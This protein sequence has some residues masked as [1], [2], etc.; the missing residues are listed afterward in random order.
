LIWSGGCSFSMFYSR[1][2]FADLIFSDS[3]V[4]LRPMAHAQRSADLVAGRALLRAARLVSCDA[5]DSAHYIAAD[6]AFLSP[7]HAL[8]PFALVLAGALLVLASLS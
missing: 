5:P 2:P 7:A 6:S 8:T 4:R 3:A 1:P